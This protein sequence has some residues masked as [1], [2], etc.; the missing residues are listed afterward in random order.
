MTVA[1]QSSLLRLAEMD[2]EVKLGYVFC[3]E[4]MQMQQHDARHTLYFIYKSFYSR[5]DLW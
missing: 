1:V 3:M 2:M 5:V 4:F